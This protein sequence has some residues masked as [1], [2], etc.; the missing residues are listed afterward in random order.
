MLGSIG[1]APDA[2]WDEEMPETVNLDA[3]IPRADFLTPQ[4]TDTPAGASGKASASMTDLS[5]GESFFSTLRK[6]DFQRETAAWSPM[7]IRDFVK[8]FIEGD[9]IPSVICWQSEARLSFVIDG[10]H[11]LS[12]IIAWGLNDYGDGDASVDFYGNIPEE[13]IRIAKKTRDLIEASVGSY[14]QYRAE[15]KTPGTY[16]QLA[17]NARALAHSTVPLLW[18]KTSDSERAERAFFTINQSAVE[19]DPT[20]LKI[21]NARSKP[22]AIAARAI[23]RNA[24]GHEYWKEFSIPAQQEI[25]KTAKAVYGSFYSPPLNPPIR[26]EELPIAGHGYGSQTLPLIF[27]F[28][29]IANGLPVIDKTKRGLVIKREKPDETQ[30]LNVI[31]NTES[32]TERLVGTHASSLGLHPAVYFYAA[33][34]RHQPTTVLAMA[35]LLMEFKASDSFLLFCSL[36]ARF[37]QFL[38]DHKMFINQLTVKH[39]SMAKGYAPMRDYYSTVFA[40][41]A[42]GDTE[43]EVEVYL[44]KHE[45]YQTL[46]KEKPILTKKAKDFSQATKQLVLLQEVLAKAFVCQICG[47]RVDKKSMQLDH[48]DDRAAGG[49]ATADNARFVHP[50]CN[51]TYK[52]RLGEMPPKPLVG[53]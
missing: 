3:L 46:V 31:R 8:A 26:T 34:G 43:Q 50:L 18:V 4:Q 12:A 44:Q 17:A 33:N 2:P 6:P 15:T 16:P 48:A 13:Q 11:R 39:G 9:L 52:K 47:A 32:L 51:S 29:N 21:L 27:D 38:V 30:T 25:V 14:R 40:R 22:N 7:M 28:V 45:R 37:E 41:I 35:S 36:R 53:F 10:A 19:I 23:V 42:A 24:T 20:E 1:G 49:L 5:K